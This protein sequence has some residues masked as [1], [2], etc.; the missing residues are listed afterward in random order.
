MKRV[1]IICEGETEKEF[2][3]KIISPFFASKNIHIQSPLIKKTMGGMV[4]WSELKKQITLHLKNDKTAFVTTLIDYYGL[5]SK[6][7]FPS[8]DESLNVVDKNFRMDFLETKMLED[9]DEQFRYRYLP[10]IQLHEFEGLLFTEI[11]VFFEQIPTHELVGIEELKQTFIDFSNPE[12]INDKKETSPSNRLQ[13]II[14]GYNKVVY[15]NYLADAIGLEKIRN[16]SYRFNNWLN[17]IE[18]L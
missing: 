13:R 18:N 16:K 7:Q 1:I 2:C 10:Y 5:Y 8:W 6:Y 11:Y 15:G 9:I 12:M 17:K 4:K 3:T 14:K